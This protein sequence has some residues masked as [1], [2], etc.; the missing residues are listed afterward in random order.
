MST[1]RNN[2]LQ[3]AAF[4]VGMPRS[5]SNLL[6][7]FL[8]T[9]SLVACGKETCF[10]SELKQ[11]QILEALSDPQWPKK[12][13]NLISTITLNKRRVIDLYGLTPSHLYSFLSCREPTRAN[14][15][16]AL[17]KLHTQEQE[18]SIWVDKTPNHILHLDKIKQDFPNAKIILMTRDPRD[19][20]ISM[21]HLP[22]AYQSAFV[23][24]SLLSGMHKN[25]NQFIDNVHDKLV[26]KFEQLVLRPKQIL[27]EVCDYLGVK[28]E[29]NMLDSHTLQNIVE[30][31]N[32]QNEADFIE[33]L[34]TSFVN[35]WQC[36]N[37]IELAK[38][39]ES[40]CVGYMDEFDYT[41]K[42]NNTSVLNKP[43]IGQN[44]SFCLEAISVDE[45]KFK[46]LDKYIFGLETKNVSLHTH[47]TSK[48]DSKVSNAPPIII[49][50]EPKFK[51]NL[52]ILFKALSAKYKMGREVYYFQQQ[53]KNG[54]CK[55][56]F[57]FFFKPIEAVFD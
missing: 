17:H 29:S 23:N 47:V 40:S 8:D 57:S 4:I 9:H 3:P 26:V 45:S 44:N 5:G 25:S 52:K 32:N 50:I 33:H 10:Y 15:F 37:N 22:W 51:T 2:Q 18:K 30:S 6:A 48:L 31:H 7:S 46:G 21:K 53:P 16:L 38:K 49:F 55:T 42:A 43:Y 36:S 1:T 54:W 35:K 12:A 13:A 56:L 34:D 11:E 19:I 39:L 20:A 14:M 27:S 41:T 24:A 28:F